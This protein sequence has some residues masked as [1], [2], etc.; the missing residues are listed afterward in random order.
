MFI[1]GVVVVSTVTFSGVSTGVSTMVSVGVYTGVSTGV[2]TMVS[3]GVSTE[4]STGVFTEVF[5]GISV[6][7]S[8]GVFEVDNSEEDV[9]EINMELGGGKV[10]GEGEFTDVNSKELA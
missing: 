1:I 8:T 6:G 9:D 10:E 3:T 7:V 5:T 4:V 2:S